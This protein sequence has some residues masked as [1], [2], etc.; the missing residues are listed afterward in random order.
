MSAKFGHWRRRAIWAVVLVGE[1]GH[2]AVGV[3]L[4]I[5]YKQAASRVDPGSTSRSE[6]LTRTRP[7]A[8]VSMVHGPS[9]FVMLGRRL[10]RLHPTKFL[11]K[12]TGT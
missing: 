9:L 7:R 12:V 6:R 4:S 3:P 10:G 8:G 5:S 1:V 2:G 11:A